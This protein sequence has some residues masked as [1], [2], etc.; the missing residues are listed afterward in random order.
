[1]KDNRLTGLIAGTIFILAISVFCGQAHSSG[2][3]ADLVVVAN[4]DTLISRIFVLGQKFRIETEEDGQQI[5]VI[6]EQ[7]TGITKV[8]NIDE[9][10]YLKV[11]ANDM[12]SHDNDPFSSLRYTLTIPDAEIKQL[13]TETVSGVECEKKTVSYDGIDYFTQWVSE[14]HELP[15]K[16]IALNEPDN[17]VKMT[18]IKDS[19]IGDELFEVPEEYTAVGGEQSQTQDQFVEREPVFPEWMKDASAAELV[20]LPMK[21][22]LLAG[23]MIRIKV[24][25][26]KD[27]FVLAINNNDG[28][29]VFLAIPCLGG[30]PIDDPSKVFAEYG[31]TRMY[32]MEIQDQAWPMNLTE[33]PDQADEV[34]IRVDKGQVNMLTQYTNKP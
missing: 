31:E 21:K 4:S 8:I 12:R 22:E 15:L 33:T 10:A 7:E 18:N 27:I 19:T 25:A 29:S 14:Q 24:L 20:E 26:G 23:E 9:K 5:V 16:I 1:M 2:F 28:K 34:L 11:P 30:Q 3:V 17:L 13:G 32:R 6:V